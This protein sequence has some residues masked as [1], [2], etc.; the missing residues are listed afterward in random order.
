TQEDI[1][2]TKE[3][4]I[5]EISNK[6]MQIDKEVNQQQDNAYTGNE[7]VKEK[8]LYSQAKIEEV[9]R[10]SQIEIGMRISNSDTIEEKREKIEELKGYQK[11][12]YRARKL[13]NNMPTNKE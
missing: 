11:A 2:V 7:Q 13:E 6:E 4:Y 10:L 8:R 3:N 12:I 1:E 9:S 5:T